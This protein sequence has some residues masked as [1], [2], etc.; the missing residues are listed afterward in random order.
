MKLDVQRHDF[1]KQKLEA[2]QV[3]Q[4]K[5]QPRTGTTCIEDGKEM[6]QETTAESKN[7]GQKLKKQ[8]RKETNNMV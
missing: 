7:T 1:L 3:F 8:E 2:H 6:N 4:E 5:P